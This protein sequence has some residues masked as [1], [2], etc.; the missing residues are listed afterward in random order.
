[1]TSTPTATGMPIRDLIR[2]ALR[3]R[4]LTVQPGCATPCGSHL[5]LS[6]RRRVYLLL[7]D[8]RHLAEF[9]AAYHDPRTAR[10]TTLI[11]YIDVSWVTTPADKVGRRPASP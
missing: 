4:V 2:S 6:G 1:M 5:V 7:G 9:R 3:T 10:A 8:D 11:G